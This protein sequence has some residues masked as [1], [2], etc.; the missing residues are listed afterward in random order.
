MQRTLTL[1]ALALASAQAAT[2]AE[3]YPS[4]N[5]RVVLGFAPGASTDTTARMIG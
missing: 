2:A 4:R 1:A 5:L 3:D